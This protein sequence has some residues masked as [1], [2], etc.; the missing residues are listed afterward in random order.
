MEDMSRGPSAILSSRVTPGRMFPVRVSSAPGYFYPGE[1]RCAMAAIL[2]ADRQTI[3]YSFTTLMRAEHGNQFLRVCANGRRALSAPRATRARAARAQA[4]TRAR[5][6]QR[7]HGLRTRSWGIVRVSPWPGSLFGFVV[8]RKPRSSTFHGH[9]AGAV[10]RRQA[11]RRCSRNPRNSRHF[12][13]GDCEPPLPQR[14]CTNLK[15]AQ[16]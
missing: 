3:M 12:G 7:T 11:G 6:G 14:R 5:T 13:P 4:C 16:W 9:R 10:D 2:T 1:C 15:G 8:R